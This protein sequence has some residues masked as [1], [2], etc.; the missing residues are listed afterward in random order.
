MKED[1]LQTL[2]SAY[3]EPIQI[4]TSTSTGGGCINQTQVLSLSNGEKAFLK[5]ND[6]PPE[7]FF[8]AEIKGLQLLGEAKDGPRVPRPLGI[9][10]G[11]KPRFLILEYIESSSAGGRFHTRFARTLSTTKD[12][13]VC[14]NSSD[15]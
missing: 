1:L 9:G 14:I 15:F 3:G 13:D 2:K 7:N 8:E 5:Y 12:Q 6:H 4:K 11:S 10:P